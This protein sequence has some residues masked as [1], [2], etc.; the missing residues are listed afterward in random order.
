MGIFEYFF[1]N[2]IQKLYNE[3]SINMSLIRQNI[4][5]FAEDFGIKFKYLGQGFEKSN[6]EQNL[7][8]TKKTLI[9]GFKNEKI[10]DFNGIMY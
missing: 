7:F 1:Y 6:K 8:V 10:S 4:E 2:D 9:L 5:Q 3:R